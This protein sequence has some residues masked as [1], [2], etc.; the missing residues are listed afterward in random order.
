MLKL[1]S[2]LKVHNVRAADILSAAYL[3]AL[4]K[5]AA[6][7]GMLEAALNN[8]GTALLQTRVYFGRL[9]GNPGGKGAAELLIDIVPSYL[10]T[11]PELES[12]MLSALRL[13]PPLAD[14]R[15]DLLHGMWGAIL[16]STGAAG[17]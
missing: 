3:S 15:A 9:T 14:R 1:P 7:W 4:G 5:I 13:V 6:E 2:G 8:H 12:K 10:R 17:H 16:E 11:R